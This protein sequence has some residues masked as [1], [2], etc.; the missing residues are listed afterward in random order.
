[1]AFDTFV[2]LDGDGDLDLVKGGTE[3]FLYV[4]ENVGGGRFVDRGRLTSAGEVL[5]F[6]HDERNRSWLSVEFCDWD[7]DGDQDMFVTCY[8]GPTDKPVVRYEN[9]TVRGGPLT[10]LDRGP[11]TTVSGRPLTDR[12]S[13]VDWDGDGRL[14]VLTSADG[15]LTFHRNVGA[16]RAVSDMALADGVYLEAN[17]VPIQLDGARIDAADIDGDGDLDLF[18]GTEEGRV[19]FFENVGTR[20]APVLAGGRLFAFFEYMDGKA[21]V[22]VADFD[23]DGLLDVAVGRYWNRTHY[24]EQP[25]VFGR[26]YRNVGTR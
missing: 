12:V 13:F 17:G 14:D 10:F 18:V 2:D 22:K 4:Y 20:T 1:S 15:I 8:A 9:V 19:Y 6:P 25:R 3:P 7:G 11:L 26:L 23:G 21:G 16:S 24:G 5:T